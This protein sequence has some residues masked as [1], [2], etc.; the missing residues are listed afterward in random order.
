SLVESVTRLCQ[1]LVVFGRG[2]EDRRARDVTTRPASLLRAGVVTMLAV[3]AFLLPALPAYADPPT[4]ELSPTSFDLNPGD[5]GTLIVRLTKTDNGSPT[6]TTFT[7]SAPSG[8]AGN[9]Q[10]RT[11]APG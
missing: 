4:L 10:V 1:N 3:G 9:V 6:P 11:S 2:G 5:S 7:V 8:L